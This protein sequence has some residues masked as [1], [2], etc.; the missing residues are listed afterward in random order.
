M[1]AQPKRTTSRAP[2]VLPGVIGVSAELQAVASLIPLMAE[3]DAT[4]LL[5]G[6]DRDGEGTIREGRFTIWEGEATSPSYR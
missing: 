3:S 6:R 2:E 1:T 4:C 5:L